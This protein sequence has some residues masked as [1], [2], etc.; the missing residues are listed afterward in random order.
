MACRLVNSITQ[1]FNFIH[2]NNRNDDISNP[3]ELSPIEPKKSWLLLLCNFQCVVL[4]Q[5]L[6]PHDKI[7]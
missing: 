6:H 2:T 3:F 5:L 4:C 7:C 1:E